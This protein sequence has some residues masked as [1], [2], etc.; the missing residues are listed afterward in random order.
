[1]T[2]AVPMVD[3]VGEARFRRLIF[4]RLFIVSFLLGIAALIQ[5]GGDLDIRAVLSTGF[6]HYRAIYVLSVLHILARYWTPS[7][8]LSLQATST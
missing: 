4:V 7:F 5:T 8:N 1:M 6:R 3:P 2:A